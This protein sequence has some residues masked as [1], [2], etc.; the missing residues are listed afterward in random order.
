MD[1][2]PHVSKIKDYEPLKIVRVQKIY[3]S[4]PK[5]KKKGNIIDIIL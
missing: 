1:N 5:P 4:K 2:I 3:K